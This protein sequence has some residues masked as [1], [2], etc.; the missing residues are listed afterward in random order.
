MINFVFA[1]MFA[2]C[3]E[4]EEEMDTAVAEEATEETTQEE[5]ETED[6][7]QEDPEDTAEAEAR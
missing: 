4:K 3:G 7:A 5:Q 2:A 6:T 1:A